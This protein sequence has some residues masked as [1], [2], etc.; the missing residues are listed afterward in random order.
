M[1]L[2]E[3]IQYI[4]GLVAANTHGD[5]QNTSL[6]PWG[7]RRLVFDWGRANYIENHGLGLV[8]SIRWT[9]ARLHEYAADGWHWEAVI[10]VL[11]DWED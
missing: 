7:E 10:E 1:N 4:Q 5:E 6:V 2:I 8:G 11:R 9:L 3:L